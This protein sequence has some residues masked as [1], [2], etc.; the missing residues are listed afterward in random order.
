MWTIE[1]SA[2]LLLCVFTSILEEM[3]TNPLPSNELFQLSGVISQYYP[4]TYIYVF[5]VVSFLLAL[6]SKSYMHSSSPSMCATCP[7][8]LILG[9]CALT[10]KIEQHKINEN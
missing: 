4:P 6:Q 3:F 2:L 10:F 5:L 8:H 1:N 7:A 9:P